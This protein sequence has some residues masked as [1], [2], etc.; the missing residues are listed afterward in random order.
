MRM[1]ETF[2]YE[3]KLPVFR[4]PECL[5]DFKVF[6]LVVLRGEGGGGGVGKY[7]VIEYTQA[8]LSKT[9]DVSLWHVLN[10]RE[11]QHMKPLTVGISS[12][13]SMIWSSSLLLGEPDCTSSLSKSPV[14]KCV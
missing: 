3:P 4:Y 13:F 7:N 14:D 11:S 1:T 12:P 9:V 5:V 8:L 10:H 2:I 6:F